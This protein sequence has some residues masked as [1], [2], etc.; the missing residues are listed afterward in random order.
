MLRFS[1]K[2]LLR[3][4]PSSALRGVREATRSCPGVRNQTLDAGQLASPARLRDSHSAAVLHADG[5]AD[6]GRYGLRAK[7]REHEQILPLYARFDGQLS[8]GTWKQV[9]SLHR[10]CP[11]RRLRRVQRQVRLQ[12]RRVQLRPGAGYQL[13]LTNKARSTILQRK[14]GPHSAIRKD[15]IGSAIRPRPFFPT[16]TISSATNSRGGTYL[17]PKTLTW[18]VATKAKPTSTPRRAGRSFPTARSSLPT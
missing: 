13:Q 12:G 10:L 4:L 14:S 16:A 7:R 9:G 1:T 15:G 18:K 5:V 8:D 3:S 17:N 6:D 2:G 11:S